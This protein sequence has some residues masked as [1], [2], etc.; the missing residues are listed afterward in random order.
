MMTGKLEIEKTNVLLSVI[1]MLLILLAIFAM[2]KLNKF[3]F[4]SR[5]GIQW[6]KHGLLAA[7]VA[8]LFAFV[9]TAVMISSSLQK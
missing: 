1:S 2:V 9:I 4:K 7:T 8:V 5:E 6:S 3:D